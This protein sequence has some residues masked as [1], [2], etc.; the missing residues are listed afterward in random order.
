MAFADHDWR[1]MIPDVE[2]VYGMLL[3]A[4]KQYPDVDW[5]H[6]RADEAA[7]KTLNISTTAL[8]LDVEIIHD[9]NSVDQLRIHSSEDT[10]GPQPFFAIKMRG[11]RYVI[12][13]LDFQVPKR[14]WSY[15]FDANTVYLK[16]IEKIGVA[17]NSVNGAGALKVI[18]VD[19]SVVFQRTW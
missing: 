8:H 15:T 6:A 16:D 12:D 18:A 10:F 7:K 11:G 17:T 19:N 2:D 13:N 5:I 4:S 14:E 3:N 1:N 9:E